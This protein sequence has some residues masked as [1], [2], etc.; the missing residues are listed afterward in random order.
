MGQLKD[1]ILDYVTY[2]HKDK[3][4]PKS[5]FK[6]HLSNTLKAYRETLNELMQVGKQGT[7]N[8]E[9]KDFQSNSHPTNLSSEIIEVINKQNKAIRSL[10]EKNKGWL[11][12]WTNTN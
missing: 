9:S 11:I 3:N 8:P 2:I 7:S 10:K 4:D 1:T 12:G 5:K 6:V